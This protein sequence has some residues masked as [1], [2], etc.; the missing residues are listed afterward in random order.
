MMTYYEII[1]NMKGDE[2]MMWNEVRRLSE[3]FETLKKDEAH[4]E[5][6]ENYLMMT[7]SEM[8]GHYNEELAYCSVIG[9]KPFFTDNLKAYMDS[10][11][12]T[13]EKV[14][15]TVKAVE[16]ATMTAYSQKGLTIPAIHEEY[17]M[18]DYYVCMADKLDHHYATIG[19]DMAKGAL[20]VYESLS[21][22]DGSTRKVWDNTKKY[23]NPCK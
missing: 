10:K 16:K 18:Y 9:M 21:D 1:K 20:L 19:E 22:Y 14:Y 15:E 17:N 8:T 6:I 23:I 5:I 12:L 4:A 13:P 11:G 7:E 2:K 3:L